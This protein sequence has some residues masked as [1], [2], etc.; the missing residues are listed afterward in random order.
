MADTVEPGGNIIAQRI[1]G[2]MKVIVD[3]ARAHQC[4]T[5][6]FILTIF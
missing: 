4:G 2:G 6:I 5:Y 3:V 1:V